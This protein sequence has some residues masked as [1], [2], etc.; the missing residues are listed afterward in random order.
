MQDCQS[1]RSLFSSPVLSTWV[2]IILLLANETTVKG[3]VFQLGA[4][5]SSQYRAH[6][7]SVAIR[8]LNYDG[9]MGIG[10]LDGLSFGAFLRTQVDGYTLGFGDDAIPF[11]VPTDVF[12]NSHYFMGR[13]LSVARVR[14]GLSIFGFAGATSLGLG[15]PFFRGARVQRDRKSVV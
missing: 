14:D 4:G 9:W 2:S 10:S 15:T 12:D 1:A 3:Q 11:R 13:G 8:G 5:T 7:G 6:G